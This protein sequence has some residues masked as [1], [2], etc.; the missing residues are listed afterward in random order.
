MVPLWMHGL[1]FALRHQN[2]VEHL[3]FPWDYDLWS[4]IEMLKARR[5]GPVPFVYMETLWS[6]LQRRRMLLEEEQV[7]VTERK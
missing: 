7:S 1:L 2:F 4:D 3:H 6:D 5:Q